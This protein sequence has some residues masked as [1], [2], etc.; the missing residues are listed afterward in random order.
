MVVCFGLL[1]QIYIVY[2]R[3]LQRLQGLQN[4]GNDLRLALMPSE[5]TFSSASVIMKIYL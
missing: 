3:A 5:Y 1:V 4:F 2:L